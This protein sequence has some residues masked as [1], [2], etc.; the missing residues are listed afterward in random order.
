MKQGCNQHDTIVGLNDSLWSGSENNKKPI[1]T[2]SI[3]HGKCSKLSS[4]PHHMMVALRV[5]R[6]SGCGL[7]TGIIWTA[8]WMREFVKTALVLWGQ[9]W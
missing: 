7:P 4:Y 9:E 8:C 6:C 2:D 5:V 3:A 1:H